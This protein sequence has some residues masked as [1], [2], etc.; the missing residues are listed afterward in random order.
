[1]TTE[2]TRIYFNLFTVVVLFFL[3]GC[4]KS[5]NS[6]P[7]QYGSVSD[8]EGNSYKTVIIGSQEWMAE[9]LRSEKLNN[10]TAI[11]LVTDN[12]TWANTTAP[13]YSFYS[14]DS[15]SY[16]N[17][18]GVLY[19]WYTVQT[20]KLCP[21]G[22]HVPSDAEF[23]TLKTTLGVDSIAGGMLKFNLGFWLSPNTYGTNSTGFTAL[24]GGYRNYN[25]SFNSSSG[26]LAAFWSKTEE[27]SYA[28]YIYLTYN[29][30]TIGR[31]HADKEYG[32]S[33]RCLK[34]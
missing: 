26:Y 15:V 21:T 19:N 24:P 10:G 18:Y 6:T 17:N 27:G 22:W 29:S 7:I 1:M 4:S 3:F 25:G 33:V 8:L 28:R 2:K 31:N 5:D 20:G 13:A 16:K 11:P 12:S 32:L 14:N 23:T 9:N 30:G 34:D